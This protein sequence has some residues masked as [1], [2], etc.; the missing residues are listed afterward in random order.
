VAA[1]PE[2]KPVVI[3][4]AGFASKESL[5]LLREKGYS[6]LVNITRGS[7]KK[8][9]QYFEAEDFSVL[10]DRNPDE[11]VEVKTIEDPEDPE[12]RLVL[13]R[14]VKRREKEQAMISKAEKKFVD[15]AESLKKRISAGRL[16]DDKKIHKAIGRLLQK[17]PRVSRYYD[18]EFANGVI[19]AERKEDV[20]AA[21]YELC[22]DY[23]LKTDQTF[24]AD[25]L[26]QLYMTL[27]K[28]EEGF[29]I[30]KGTLGLRPNFHQKETRVDGHIFMTVL[31]YHLLSWINIKFEAAGDRRTWRTLRR[32][33]RT[34]SIL[35]TR[36]PLENGDTVS[37]R[38]ASLPNEEQIKIYDTLGIN[39]RN[40]Y[41]TKKSQMN[42]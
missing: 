32:I 11:Q 39:W 17:H 27:L 34:H 12:T 16:K 29:K 14:S 37:V 13:C 26:W 15:D 6:Y 33:L 5:Q 24:D 10:A 25:V 30:L 20:I 36:F 28:A 42:A 19:S 18:V 2:Q 8:Y 41:K 23:V 40:A 7:R 21:A 22:G 31:A 9:A 3:L 38:K 4:D 1:E 35:T